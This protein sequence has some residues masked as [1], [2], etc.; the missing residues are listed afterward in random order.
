MINTKFRIDNFNLIQKQLDNVRKIFNSNAFI[1]FLKPKFLET[2]NETINERLV[3]TSTGEQ[4]GVTNSEYFDEYKANNKFLDI[5]DGF[6]LYNDTVIPQSNLTIQDKRKLANYP[7]GFSIALAFEFGVG[8]VGQNAPVEG[9][10]QYNVNNYN[11]YWTFKKNGQVYSTYGYQGMEI[12]R[13]TVV[14]INNNMKKWIN[15]YFS[16][17]L[18]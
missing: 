14:K 16:K 2:L 17:S 12:Y 8:I 18:K 4:A 6:I 10:W 13:F 15:E 9:A 5:K 3:S 1:N 7:N 11:F